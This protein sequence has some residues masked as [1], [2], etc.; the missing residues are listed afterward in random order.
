MAINAGI[1]NRPPMSPSMKK[2]KKREPK[3]AYDAVVKPP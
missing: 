3:L 1:S 2:A